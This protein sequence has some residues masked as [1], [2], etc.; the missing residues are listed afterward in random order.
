MF[1]EEAEKKKTKAVALGKPAAGLNPG[2]GVA[3]YSL[4]MILGTKWSGF[5]APVFRCEAT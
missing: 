3:S 5:G 1:P 2:A 4:W